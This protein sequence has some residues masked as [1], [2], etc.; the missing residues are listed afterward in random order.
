M[1]GTLPRKRRLPQM[2]KKTSFGCFLSEGSS[3]PSSNC[4]IGA[5][6]TASGHSGWRWKHLTSG[7]QL[8]SWQM[9]SPQWMQQEEESPRV[10][11]GAMVTPFSGSCSNWIKADFSLHKTARGCRGVY[12]SFT[13]RRCYPPLLPL[14]PP[15]IHRRTLLTRMKAFPKSMSSKIIGEHTSPMSLWSRSCPCGSG[16]SYRWLRWKRMGGV[17]WP[18]VVFCC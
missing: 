3:F 17:D 15:Q 6:C 8:S 4:G 9:P 12:F 1:P 18:Q 11:S 7:G 13:S 14:L 2:C 5:L 10:P 16:A